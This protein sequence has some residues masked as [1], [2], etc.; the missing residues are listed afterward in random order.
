MYTFL[1][2]GLPPNHLMMLTIPFSLY[3]LFRLLYLIHVRHEGGA[4]EEILLRDRP[5][6][7]T[8]GLWGVV[9]FLALYV[10]S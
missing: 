7:V 3:T 8:L 10:F 6:Q 1:S 9:I 4:P 2:E 5:L